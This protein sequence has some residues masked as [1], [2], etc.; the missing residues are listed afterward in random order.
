MNEIFEFFEQILDG[1]TEEELENA[2]IGLSA[3][4]VKDKGLKTTIKVTPFGA[5]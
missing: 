3:R 2:K 4:Y 5:N 1:N